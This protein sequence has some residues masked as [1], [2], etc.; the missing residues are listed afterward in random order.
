MEQKTINKKQSPL[1]IV[2]KY[3][4]I[5]SGIIGIGFFIAFLVYFLTR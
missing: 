5:G 3:V 1:Y 2:F 4:A